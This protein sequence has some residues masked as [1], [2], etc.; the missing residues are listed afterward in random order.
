MSIK[1]NIVYNSILTLSQYVVLLIIFPYISRI[2][3]VSNLGKISFIDNSINYFILFSTLGLASVGVREIAKYKNDA[4]KLN[5]VFSSLLSLSVILSL[6]VLIIYSIAILTIPQFT[7]YKEAFFIGS[8][9]IIFTVF[10]IEWLY[11]GVEDFKYITIRNIS[12]NLFYIVSILI[13]VK[14]RED[15]LIYFFL[16]ICTV[17]I[18]AIINM[19]YSRHIVKFSLADINI[20]PY[21]NQLVLLGSYSILTSMYTTFNVMYLGFVSD[22]MQIGYYW[23]A[24]K[25]YTIIIGLFTAFTSVMMPRMSSLL[26]S[27]NNAEFNVIINKS[28]NALFTACF[29]IIIIG[30]IL[31][32]NIVGI[33]AGNGYEGAIIP[34]QII[35]PLVLFVGIAQIIANQ[36]LMPMQKDKSVFTASIIGA[37]V[38]IISNMIFVKDYGAVGTSFVLLISEISVTTY[39]LYFLL[40]N[41]IIVFPLKSLLRNLFYSIP[42]IFIS[43]LGVVIFENS[44]LLFLFVGFLSIMYFLFINIFVFK[45]L[46]ILNLLN[47]IKRHIQAS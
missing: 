4:E 45:D 39:Y 12:I 26:F 23:T 14:K 40:K 8:A 17:V 24:L 32:P 38:G 41:N 3:G 43:F 30:V 6:I 5:S 44:I 16:T 20:K 15:Y 13:F 1:K 11:K 28:F 35:M 46:E 33:I 27:G 37:C 21:I 2:L 7:L 25:I 47:R 29:P 19:F 9:K 22:S 42:Y 10:L 34:M 18:N 31:A 36:I